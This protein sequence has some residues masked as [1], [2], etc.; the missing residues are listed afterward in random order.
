[1]LRLIFLRLYRWIIQRDIDQCRY[2][3]ANAHEALAH[4]TLVK[5]R[6]DGEIARQELSIGR[7]PT[8]E[9]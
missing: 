1:M 2:Q 8:V 3:M 5:S 9:R 4:Y 6:L 7:M